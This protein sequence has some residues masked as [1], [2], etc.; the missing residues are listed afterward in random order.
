ME[1][2]TAEIVFGYHERT[3][4][5]LDRYAAGPETLDWTAQPDPFREFREAPRFLLPL[6]AAIPR[7]GGDAAP[8]TLEAVAALLR[9]SMGISAWKVHGPD[10]W[11]LRCNPSS[12]NLHPTE[13]YVLAR[14]VTGFE[15]GLYHYSSSDHALERRCRIGE[16]PA[17]LWVGLSSIHWREAWKYGE[18]A[19]RYCQLDIGH[20]LGALRYAAATLGWTPSLVGGC[21]GDRLAHLLG[22]DRE[23]DFGTVEKEDP[24]LL[25]SLAPVCLPALPEEGWDWTGKANRLDPDPMYRWPVIDAVAAATRQR[26]VGSGTDGVPLPARPRT[27][28]SPFLI[29]ERRSAQRFD[30]RVTAGGD[31]FFRILDAL[32]GGLP[33]DVWDFAPR[34]HPVLFV[35]RVEGMEPGL[36]I[37]PRSAAAEAELRRSLHSEF[38]WER[39]GMPGLYLLRRGDC[40]RVARIVSCHQAIAADSSFALGLLAEFGPVVGADSWRYRQLHWEAGLIGQA[41]YLEAEAAGLRGTGIGCFFDHAMH[42]FLGI[43]DRQFQSLYHFTIGMPV[44]DERIATFPAYPARLIR[45]ECRE[46][47]PF[48]KQESSPLLPVG[49]P[50][51]GDGTSPRLGRVTPE[52]RE[53][54]PAGSRSDCEPAPSASALPHR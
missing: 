38:L 33:F 45:S 12:G 20:A 6:D 7:P 15:D 40:R 42:E 3:G 27:P 17:G 24:D 36:Y 10:R 13:T 16:G 50:E 1:T 52:L 9:L 21:C 26:I 32:L 46:R 37:L 5:R 11:A 43:R 51:V 22:L 53:F 49:L 39:T 23:D 25:L 2:S 35:H 31:A 44:T 54:R 41:L 19:F 30:P 4:H 28:P 29:L 14:G 34:L 8:L 47:V 18:R 48:R